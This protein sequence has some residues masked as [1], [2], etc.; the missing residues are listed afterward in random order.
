[1]ASSGLGVPSA[2][3]SVSAGVL[4]PRTRLGAP[5]RSLLRGAAAARPDDTAPRRRGR[6]EKAEC[7]R[8]PFAS[9]AL[10]DGLG[11]VSGDLLKVQIFLLGESARHAG[12]LEQPR[13]V[14]GD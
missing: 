4:G 2:I 13:L 9:D 5:S 14:L 1:V 11:G 7:P 12:T 8:I 3:S 10:L 6:L